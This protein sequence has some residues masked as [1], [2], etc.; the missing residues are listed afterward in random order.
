[1]A[2]SAA[3][4]RYGV[5][6]KAERELH[7]HVHARELFPPAEPAVKTLPIFHLNP[8]DEIETYSVSYGQGA[9]LIAAQRLRWAWRREDLKPMPHVEPVGS[10]NLW[11]DTRSYPHHWHARTSASASVIAMLDRCA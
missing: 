4:L 9:R 6:R 3:A 8:D 10:C 1:M 2:R 7:E 5:Q 11:T